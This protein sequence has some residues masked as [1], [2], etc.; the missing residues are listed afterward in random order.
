MRMDIF[1]YIVQGAEIFIDN[2]YTYI[3]DPPGFAN[4]LS[5]VHEI[6][7]LKPY[8]M[9]I[10][11]IFFG[12]MS[13]LVMFIVVR[14]FFGLIPGLFAS[15]LLSFSPLHIM[16]S[17]NGYPMATSVFLILICFIFLKIIN[18]NKNIIYFIAL[19]SGL[20]YAALIYH[21]EII[22]IIPI[23]LYLYLSRK[24][25]SNFHLKIG[26][27][28]LSYFILIL[29]FFLIQH[30]T[31]EENSDSM[32][33]S[34]GSLPCLWNK[35]RCGTFFNVHN[36]FRTKIDKIEERRVTLNN[37]T[38]NLPS[39]LSFL[40]LGHG[41]RARLGQSYNSY[42]DE[43][44]PI[45]TRIIYIIL[46]IIFFIPLIFSK[47]NKDHVLFIVTLYLFILEFSLLHN[48]IYLYA[49]Y[50]L[51]LGIIP[52]TAL[53]FNFLFDFISQRI[54]KKYR[55]II[56]LVLFLIPIIP[57]LIEP[58][59]DLSP[60]SYTKFTMSN[61]HEYFWNLKKCGTPFDHLREICKKV[62]N[63]LHTKSISEKIISIT[64]R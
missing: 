28:I 10:T 53:G 38:G 17:A 1:E 41:S 32:G 51:V 45:S 39:Y 16:A 23:I 64:T 6:I 31:P 20:S 15:M 46:S 25:I 2:K 36:L 12:T 60:L 19:S 33:D 55:I 29:P 48:P 40:F 62:P 54:G 24:R 43:F 8:N 57:F 50:M 44:Q 9:L 14:L 3:N 34:D 13:I 11:N 61:S 5:L 7:G 52:I 59:I 58:D 4:I 18:I 63:I 37:M 47:L 27:F 49:T 42:L 30:S 35:Q 22:I 26:L 56:L 21:V